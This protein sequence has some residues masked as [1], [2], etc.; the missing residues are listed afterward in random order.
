MTAFRALGRLLGSVFEMSRKQNYRADLNWEE[1]AQFETLGAM[2]DC[3]RS[4]VLTV[5]STQY[6]LRLCALMGMNTFQLYTEDT[7][8]VSF[9]NALI[10]QPK[11]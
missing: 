6:L 1:R 5:D 4:A 3:S 7:Y 11:Y 2:I 9:V 10:S 8:Q